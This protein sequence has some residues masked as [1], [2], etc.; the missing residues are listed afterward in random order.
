MATLPPTGTAWPQLV[1]Q[2]CAALAASNATIECTF[3]HLEVVLPGDAASDAPPPR[4]LLH[5]TICLR[6]AAER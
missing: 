4:W 1:E 5:G 6:A 3:E 2:A